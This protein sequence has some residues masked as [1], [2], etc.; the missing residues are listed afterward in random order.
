MALPAYRVAQGLIDGREKRQYTAGATITKNTFVTLQTD[1]KVDPSGDNPAGA[2]VGLAL[3]AATDGDSVLVA[4]AVPGVVY[5]AAVKSGT[6]AQA[7]VG[8]PCQL[9]I[10]GL[11]IGTPGNSTAIPVGL[12]ETDDDASGTR[13]V[14]FHIPP[15]KSHAVGGEVGI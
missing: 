13:R 8:N 12:D 5:S 6:W 1:G 14:L 15:A 9:D 4:C 7:E 11:V 2:V 10:T 3:E